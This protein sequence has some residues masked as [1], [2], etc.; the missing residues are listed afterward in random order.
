MILA[1]S[2]SRRFELLSHITKN[3]K[4]K[5]PDIDEKVIP[6]EKPE[7]YVRRLS[8]QKAKKTLTLETINE[9]IIGADTIVSLDEKIIGKPKN[10]SDFIGNMFLLSNREH[11]VMTGLTVISSSKAIS[12]ITKTKVRFKKLTL[13]DLNSYWKT[14]EPKGAAGGDA[15]QGSG[16]KFIE[17][18]S[19]SYTNIIGLPLLDLEEILGEFCEL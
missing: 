4:V 17:K 11:T 12:R 8:F 2:S 9:V 10:Y 18:I 7:T 1:S 6:N 5:T 19:G 14:K 3:F 15:V 13:E 16:S